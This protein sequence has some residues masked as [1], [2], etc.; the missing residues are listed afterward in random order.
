V[1]P[2]SAGTYTLQE[3]PS[4]AWRTNAWLRGA[5]P[6]GTLRA[7][8]PALTTGTRHTGDCTALRSDHA[9]RAPVGSARLLLASA[10]RP[11]D[12]AH[13]ARDRRRRPHEGPGDRR[14]PPDAPRPWQDYQTEARRHGP[15]CTTATG[16]PARDH[17]GTMGRP[18]TTG[19]SCGLTPAHAGRARHRLGHRRTDT[20]QPPPCAPC[21]THH[22]GAT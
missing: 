19:I 1:R 22:A 9:S 8:T 5:R 14:P 13:R 11:P 3:T 21:T 12:S 2:S 6:G 18:P 7:R 20:P 10:W 15:A 4:F 17:A 16:P